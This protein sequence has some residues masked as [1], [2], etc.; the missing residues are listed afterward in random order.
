MDKKT[1]L[2]FVLAILILSGICSYLNFQET[3][4]IEE[5]VSKELKIEL[6]KQ[7]KVLNDLQSDFNKL[8]D[9]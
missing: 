1:I 4:I 2:A 5:T 8:S 9:L 7:E 3:K 6:L